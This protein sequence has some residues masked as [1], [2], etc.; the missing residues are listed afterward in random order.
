M[1]TSYAS[2]N[3]FYGKMSVRF[4]LTLF[5]MGLFGDAHRRG[6]PLHKIWHTYSTIMKLSIVTPHLKKVSK[7]YESNPNPWSCWHS[8]FHRNSANFAMS[9]NTNID[10]FLVYDFLV[11]DSFAFFWDFKD[12]F[13][14]HGYNFDDVSKNGHSRFLIIKTF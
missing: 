10:S 5:R 9:R 12:R 3:K 2:F 14:K 6:F 8:I 4:V 1:V 13:N 7:I 11:Y